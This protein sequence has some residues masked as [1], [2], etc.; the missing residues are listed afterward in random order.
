MHN[1]TGPGGGTPG[2]CV[3]SSK[4]G[5]DQKAILNWMG[6]GEPIQNRRYRIKFEDGRVLEG[7]TD[8]AGRTDQLQS[9]IGFARYR[10]EL[11]PD[12]P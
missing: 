10:L 3:Q 11:P 2:R 12:Q 1:I 7:V 4:A 6:T 8:V 9:E 5:F